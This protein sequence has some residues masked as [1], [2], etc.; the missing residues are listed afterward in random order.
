MR[1]RVFHV[2]PERV[3][4]TMLAVYDAVQRQAQ[5]GELEVALREPKRTKSMNDALWPS[6][7]DIAAQC[8]LVIDGE[9]QQGDEHDWKS[10]FTA[11]LHG[12]QR[13]AKGINGGLVFLGAST[14]R[15]RKAEFCDLLTL[16][17]AYGDEHSVRWSDPA[18]RSFEQYPEMVKCSGQ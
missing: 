13:V 2:K 9:E 8:R 12:E 14:R 1:E 4:E 7:R 5:Q 16:I 15:M 17:R 6:L 3:R 11:A 10:V 18:L